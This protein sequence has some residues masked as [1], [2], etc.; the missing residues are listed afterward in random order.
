MTSYLDYSVLKT[1][2]TSGWNTAVIAIPTFE[3]WSKSA[4]TNKNSI[5]IKVNPSEAEHDSTGVGTRDK[6]ITI[7]EMDLIT[8]SK[9]NSDLYLDEVRRLVNA[10]ITY[11]W[12]HITTWKLD[13]TGT[14]VIWKIKG[15]E[16]LRDY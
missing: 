4:V 1:L 3:K 14:Y 8:E 12:R 11:G 9:T 15:N 2:L 5:M 10:K 16:L 7:F 13:D 6:I